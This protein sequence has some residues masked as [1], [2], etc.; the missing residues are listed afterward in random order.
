MIAQL[1]NTLL[2]KPLFNIL[3]ALYIFIPGGDFGIAIILLTV[4]IKLLLY[5]L[6][7][8]AIRSQKAFAILQPQI[9]EIQEKYKNE[10]EK[11]AT[12]IMALYKR[13]KVNPFS[14]I[15]PLF[16]QLPVLI[17]LYW[18]FQ[19]GIN[20]EHMSELY[21]F[22][23]VPTQI[24]ASLLGI[25]DLTKPNIVLAVLSG[26]LQYWQAKMSLFQ[27]KS[28]NKEKKKQSDFSEIMGK[29]MLYFM[30]IFT[31]VILFSLPSAIGLYWSVSTLFMIVQ[32]YIINKKK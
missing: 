11:Q 2:Y 31:V 29:Q 18:V 21:S 6:N 7:V 17:A 9:K 32:Q 24:K 25:I 3:I 14:G 4:L 30:P 15:A 8:K 16:I 12:E 13:E 27:N 26:I 23:P 5:P 20:M 10:K 28:A 1:F 19:K 22:M